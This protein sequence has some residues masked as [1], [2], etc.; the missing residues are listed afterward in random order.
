ME[1]E[2]GKEEEESLVGYDVKMVKGLI[3]M[4]RLNTTL[5]GLLRISQAKTTHFAVRPVAASVRGCVA[6]WPAPN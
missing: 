6:K 1:R 4:G 2:G 3:L 5:A